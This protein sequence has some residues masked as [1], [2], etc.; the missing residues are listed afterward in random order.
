[1]FNQVSVG[2]QYGVERFVGPQGDGVTGHDVGAVKKVGD[3]AKALGFALGK[4]RAIADIQAHQLGVFDRRAGGENFEIKGIRAFRQALQDQLV[5]IHFER[6]T[7]AV[8]HH[9]GQIQVFAV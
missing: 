5:A 1:M 9:A 3:A 8:D 7:L 2:E 4:K 6:S